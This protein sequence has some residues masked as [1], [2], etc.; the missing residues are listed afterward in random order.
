[1][2]DKDEL[3]DEQGQ[4]GSEAEQPLP[5]NEMWNGD[6][7]AQ[8]REE[9]RQR[10]LGSQQLGRDKGEEPEAEGLPDQLGGS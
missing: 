6:K 3:R 4:E 7:P 9:S 8:S 5:P 2:S 10:L 1:M